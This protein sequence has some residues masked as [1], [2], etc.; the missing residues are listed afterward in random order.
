MTERKKTKKKYKIKNPDLFVIKDIIPH[1]KLYF[2][3][4]N[5][6][7]HKGKLRVPILDNM[8]GNSA[9]RKLISCKK[10]AES[11]GEYDWAKEIEE[12]EN[13]VEISGFNRFSEIVV[14]SNNDKNNPRIYYHEYGHAIE[15]LSKMSQLPP[16]KKMIW[17]IIKPICNTIGKHPFF[18][19]DKEVAEFYSY[20]SEQLCSEKY[21]CKTNLNQKIVEGMIDSILFIACTEMNK[22]LENVESNLYSPE[23]CKE[24][25]GK[26]RR[27]LKCLDYIIKDRDEHLS[28]YVIADIMYNLAKTDRNLFYRP[29]DEIRYIYF[30]PIL[31][32]GYDWRTYD[33]NNNSHIREQVIPI[34]EKRL[35]EALQAR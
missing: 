5:C 11:S 8:H 2:D 22:S 31:D 17:K 10:A 7:N 19:D 35:R 3:I 29:N 6:L 16:Y 4:P 18:K 28:T 9:Y 33:E 13:I 34:A 25:Q 14:I 24:V 32:L 1:L 12:Y 20:I 27:T 15:Y 30:E 23:E 26:S 21:D